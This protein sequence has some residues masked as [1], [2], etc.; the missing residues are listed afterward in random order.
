M[1][2]TSPA[3]ASRS[4][5]AAMAEPCAE[6]V[7]VVGAGTMGVGIAYV[8]AAAGY[9][10]ALVE[11]DDAR[12]AAARATLEGAAASGVRRGKLASDGAEALLAR[13]RRFAEVADLPL[14][15]DLAIETVPER[16]D[17]KQRVLADLSARAPKLIATNTS[18]MSIDALAGCVSRP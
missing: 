13:I 7:A 18:S 9:D 17:V 12:H 14:G 8:F 16:A 2:A 11:P 15:L 3:R 4:T 5:E 10:V 1:R 6:Q